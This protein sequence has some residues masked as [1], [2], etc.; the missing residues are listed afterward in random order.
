MKLV[1]II[2]EIVTPAVYA[3]AATHQAITGLGATT[4]VRIAMKPRRW[5]AQPTTS[6]A[7]SWRRASFPQSISAGVIRESLIEHFTVVG[8]AMRLI[9][10]GVALL[11]ALA[12]LGTT[13]FNTLD[14]IRELAIL[15]AIGAPPASLVN[16]LLIESGQR[17]CWGGVVGVLLSLAIS[18]ALLNAGERPGP[19]PCPCSSRGWALGNL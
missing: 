17:H 9:A 3:S 14:R 4:S 18:R 1:G 10:L 8:E 5:H 2:D 16:M 11:G 13:L 15:K 6:T 19:S 12:L 7:H